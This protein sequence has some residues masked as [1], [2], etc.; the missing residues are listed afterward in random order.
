MRTTSR[1]TT[2]WQL[3][4]TRH[5]HRIFPPA[6]S[7]SERVGNYRNY[8]KR[9]T[10]NIKTPRRFS[11]RDYQQKKGSPPKGEK[12]SSELKRGKA[13]TRACKLLRDHN[14]EVSSR[15]GRHIVG[16]LRVR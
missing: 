15:G 1:G 5:K 10:V 3:R 7:P 2:S 13:T 16:E 14:L 4:A 8:N 12:P 11:N 9:L 6:Q